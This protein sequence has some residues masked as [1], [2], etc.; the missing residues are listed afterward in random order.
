MPLVVYV[1]SRITEFIDVPVPDAGD[2]GKA[3]AYDHADGDFTYV[4]FE[5][6]GAFAAHVEASDPHEAYL[7]A[8][9]SRNGATA[10]T[11]AFANPIIVAD[12]SAGAPGLA[13]TVPTTGFFRESSVAIGVAIAGA[14]YFLFDRSSN[15]RNPRQVITNLA[16]NQYSSSGFILRN[17]EANDSTGQTEWHL[18]AQKDDAGAGT[19]TSSLQIRKRND[20]QSA[21]VTFIQ[22][23]GNNNLILQAGYTAGGQTQ[24]YVAIGH[25]APTALLDLGGPSTA[26]AQF[27]I[28]PG[29][30][31]ASPNDGDI[32]YLTA[33]RL[34]FRR[35][36]T[37]EIIA[38]GVT[39]TGGAATAT[40][41]YGATEQAMLQAVYDAARSFA[42]LT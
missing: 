5:A 1:P 20:S 24:G 11:Q 41:T 33:G 38:S 34:Q 4:A 25:L 18:F 16:E 22:V 30:N 17:V 13:F 2:D 31:V 23:L 27:R 40:G 9:G 32:W 6:A 29:P 35:S 39:A 7:L 37:T 26:R 21:A 28:R 10:E 42:L 19:G 15:A 36:S 3:L 14:K 12:G 8:D